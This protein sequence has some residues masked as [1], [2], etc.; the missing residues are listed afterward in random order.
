MKL[1]VF[2]RATNVTRDSRLYHAPDRQSA[3]HEVLFD[4]ALVPLITAD[5]LY[6]LFA[7]LH[8]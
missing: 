8:H 4:L 2:S 3:S 5:D 7:L 1:E 6:I